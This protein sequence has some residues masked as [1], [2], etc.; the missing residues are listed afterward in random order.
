MSTNLPGAIGA[1]SSAL[2][3]MEERQ[4]LL[5][6]QLISAKQQRIEFFNHMVNS[7][8]PNISNGTLKRLIYAAPEFVEEHKLKDIFKKYK[9]IFWLIK[10]PGYREVLRSLQAQL[11]V[12]LERQRYMDCH[13]KLIMDLEYEQNVISRQQSEALEI[14]GLMEKALRSK[15]RLP[16]EVQNSIKLLAQRGRNTSRAEQAQLQ[17]GSNRFLGGHESTLQPSHQSD[18]LWLWM[19]MD[20]PTSF[21][22]LLL[23]AFSHSPE[24]LHSIEMKSSCSSTPIPHHVSIDSG[25]SSGAVVQDDVA[26][27]DAHAAQDGYVMAIATDDRLGAYS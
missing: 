9:K 7:L 8:V 21:R 5:S 16:P 12:Y 13:D 6:K 11:K 19:M 2:E 14:L 15:M 24:A 25:C 20:I 17:A 26:V 10:P 23:N 3:S 18:M 4:R 22:T 1:L 27:F